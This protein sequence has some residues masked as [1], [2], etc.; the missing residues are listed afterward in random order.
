MSDFD[1]AAFDET[2][3]RADALLKAQGQEEERVVLSL[4]RDEAVRIADALELFAGID[5]GENTDTNDLLAL[6]ALV[7]RHAS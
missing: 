3:A 4:A 7:R 1:Q 6:A 2:L 5:E